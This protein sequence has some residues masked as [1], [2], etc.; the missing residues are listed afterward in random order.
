MLGA[1]GVAVEAP[2][3]AELDV[4]DAA[5]V[6]AALARAR[7]DVVFHCAAW[8]DVDGAERDP[9]GAERANVAGSAVVARA[10]AAAGCR[11]V[12]LSTDFVFDGAK[13]APYVESDAPAPLS[14]YGRTKLAGERA[15]LAAHPGGAWIARTAW[16][17]DE[18]ARNFPALVLR[19][20]RERGVVR[21][22]VDQVG[23]PTYAGHLAEALVALPDACPPGLVHLAGRGAATRHAWAL[24]VVRAAGLDVPVEEARAAEFPAPAA[25]PAASALR[26]EHACTPLLPPWTEGVRACLAPREAVA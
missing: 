5:A 13:G 15:V 20:A 26:S 2:G 21:A 12:A 10:C 23:S 18:G 4:A 7:P 19:L 16:V 24:A 3:R 17:Y 22:A 9:A 25:R 6:G 11:L 14:A 8:T 1:A